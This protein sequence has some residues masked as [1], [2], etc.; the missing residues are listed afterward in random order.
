MASTSGI[1]A[2]DTRGRVV[3]AEVSQEM[4]LGQCN[5]T[6]IYIVP[7]IC[8]TKQKSVGTECLIRP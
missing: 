3:I 6:A 8:V 2:R 5:A 4:S 1:A 7:H